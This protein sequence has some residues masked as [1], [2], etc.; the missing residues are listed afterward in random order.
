MAL[1]S[2]LHT[3]FAGIRN[4]EA[5]IYTTSSNVTNADKPGYT[6]KEIETNYLS[7]NGQTVAFSTSLETVDYNLY[8]FEN[9][10]EDTTIASLHDT[11]STYMTQYSAQL[12]DN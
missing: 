3:S 8:L 10:I 1:T 2:A 4:T 11:I 6:R 7:V 5:K 12:G 9:L